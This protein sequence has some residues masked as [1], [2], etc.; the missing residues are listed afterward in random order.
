M[1][2]LSYNILI[3]GKPRL[4]PLTTVIASTH[5]DIIGLAEATNA[6]VVEELAR[7][8]NMDFR[9]TGR[10]TYPR[11]WQLALL[12][13]YPIL[14]TQIHE[15]P[16]VFTRKHFLEVTVDVPTLGPVTA[17]VIHQTADFYT[18]KSV[19]VRRQEV[20]KMLEI[21]SAKRGKPHAVMGDFNSIAP[22]DKLEAS[23]LIRNWL[24]RRQE[25]LDKLKKEQPDSPHFSRS[26]NARRMLQRALST[27]TL[28]NPVSRSLFNTTMQAF[29]RGGI[30]LLQKAGYTDCF[31]HVH[32][33]ALGFTCPAAAPSGRIDFIFVSPELAAHLSDCDIVTEGGGIFAEQASDHF[34]VQADFSL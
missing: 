34:P 3:G 9:L 20:Q 28:G 18:R 26:S 19:E 22:G 2:I 27:V 32:P 5:A 12:S 31:R 16:D 33:H 17:F 10:G 13:R 15:Y 7:R 21:M 29:A 8:L 11:D 6:G 30:D 23:T 4:E 24:Q 1:H 14:D 25:Y